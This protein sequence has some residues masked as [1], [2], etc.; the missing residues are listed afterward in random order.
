MQMVFSSS[1]PYFMMD[2][3]QQHDDSEDHQLIYSKSE[4]RQFDHIPTEK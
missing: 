2:W 3:K 1:T 4:S